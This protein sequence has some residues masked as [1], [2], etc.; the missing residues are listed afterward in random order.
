MASSGVV[1]REPELK[2][3]RASLESALAGDAQVVL[4]AGD[5]GAGKSTLLAAF[6]EQA[7]AAH[8]DLIVVGGTC[9]PQTGPSAP[10]LPFQEILRQLTDD[11][12]IAGEAGGSQRPARVKRIGVAVGEAL[13]DFAPDLIGLLVPGATLVAKLGKYV[14]GKSNWM[15]KLRTKAAAPASPPKSLDASQ[16]YE[17]YA[18]VIRQLSERAPLVLLV[19]DLQWADAASLE[20]LFR[21]GRRLEGRRVLLVGAYRPSDVALGRA[22]ER[23]PLEQILA[24]LKRYRGDV[25][26][27]LDAATETRGL[28]FVTALLAAEEN[29]LSPEFAVALHRHT[30]GHA[31]FTVELLRAMQERGAL[32]RGADGSWTAPEDLAWSELP[33]RVEGV[34]EERLGRLQTEEARTLTIGSV[35]GER[36]TLE[37]VARVQKADPRA[38]VRELGETLQKRHRLI[39]ADGVE[40]VGANRLSHYR[41]A[42]GQMQEYLYRRLDEVEASYLHEDVG[43]ALEELHGEN[44]PQATLQLA[45]HFDLAG[46][47]QKARFYLRQAAEQ[48]ARVYANEAALAHYA[49]ALELTPAPETAER[50]A[51]LEGRSRVNERLARH[52]DVEADLD[53]MDEMAAR[54][55]ALPRAQALKLR[56]E[57]EAKTGAYEAAATH[58]SQAVTAA[59]Q[60]GAPELEAW[61]INVWGRALT[62]QAQY[63]EAQEK[64][65]AALALAQRL[66]DKRM[67]ASCFT[68]LGITADLRGDRAAS[69][70]YFQQALA[71]YREEGDVNR[72][73]TS[74]SNLAIAKWRAG[75]LAAAEECCHEALALFRRTGDLDGQ[76]KALGNLAIMLQD[77]GRYA[78]ALAC[79]QEALALNRDI[80]CPYNVART[81][82]IIANTLTCQGDLLGAR[83]ANLEALEIDRAVSDRQDICYR[84]QS[85][86]QLAT[87]LG[88]FEAAEEHL[89]AG[90]QL[91]RQIGDLEAERGMLALEA[92]LALRLG[93]A[94]RALPKA[95]RAREMAVEL[96]HAP[97]VCGA[98]LL[99]GNA[100][101]AL[102]AFQAAQ[103]AFEQAAELLGAAGDLAACAGLSAVAQAQGDTAT[104]VAALEPHFA[105]LATQPLDG[106]G[107]RFEVFAPAY[108]ALQGAN[109][110]RAPQVLQNARA[111]LARMAGLIGDEQV[112][113]RF[114]ES[115]PAHAPFS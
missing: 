57:L 41:F 55:G 94:A 35:E 29:E 73:A 91:A 109:D 87:T 89:L 15:D 101:L 104:A 67:A 98:L 11:E 82:G 56:A 97:G 61:S 114:L 50:F 80:G 100:H 43:Y 24:E 23:H 10:F 36:F 107:D 93:D 51:L 3:L 31:L 17:Q 71:A 13:V 22:G 108:A 26:M 19:D 77:Q 16:V 59:R 1:G 5:A 39:S 76:G 40:R 79:A 9:D 113:R 105:T 66:G 48:A 84:Q 27:D 58:A 44:D 8:D 110:P 106:A 62:W 4:V 88:E 7:E 60:A 83:A 75:D 99:L 14:V 54:L 30:G 86:A 85:L 92:R 52:S 81:V 42:Y 28:E 90:L 68:N 103:A 112:R 69:L 6:A 49:R 96:E 63:Q 38:L 115:D 2:R 46:V 47:Q 37:V 21:L 78:E 33:S 70:G 18:T 65:L 111:T 53:E 72:Q 34:I 95:E 32:V 20:L 12:A 102:G 74:L 45:R 64:L 25:V